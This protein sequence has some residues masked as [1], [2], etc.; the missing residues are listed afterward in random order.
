MTPSEALA[1]AATIGKRLKDAAELEAF[2]MAY[3]ALQNPL[4]A[5]ME[6][7][8]KLRPGASVAVQCVELDPEFGQW[9]AWIIWYDPKPH[10][11]AEMGNTASDA[12]KKLREALNRAPTPKTPDDIQYEAEE[13]V[14]MQGEMKCAVHPMP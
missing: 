7:V 3:R 8:R 14:A 4:E 12:L 5:Q 13:R 11:F 10:E 2:R 6:A 9:R 1:I